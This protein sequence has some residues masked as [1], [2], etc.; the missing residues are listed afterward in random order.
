MSILS[1]FMSLAFILIISN[2]LGKLVLTTLKW[3]LK[4][5]IPIGYF[6]LLSLSQILLIPLLK[7]G[8]SSTT[9][10]FSYLFL[11]LWIMIGMVLYNKK[12]FKL[13]E[14]FQFINKSNRRYSLIVTI[15]VIILT[16][17]IYIFIMSDYRIDRMSDSAFYIP[18][19]QENIM[20]DSIYS[21]NPWSGI[22]E[23]YSP[24]YRY[25]SYELLHAS[26]L[27]LL[28]I[29]PVIYINHFLVLLNI[30]MILLTSFE[31]VIALFK[32]KYLQASTFIIYLSIVFCFV[33]GIEDGFF[34]FFST[35]MIQRLPYSGKVL[36]YLAVIPMFFLINK[37]LFNYP[38][39]KNRLLFG[40]LLI[41]L[42]STALTATSVFVFGIF[43]VV[44]VLIRLYKKD[45]YKLT[46]GYCLTTMPLILHVILIKFHILFIPMIIIYLILFLIYIHGKYIKEL[47]I[48][49]KYVMYIAI[50][51][52][53]ILSI[54][55]NAM[56][57]YDMIE[58]IHILKFIE[59]IGQTLTIR[60]LLVWG[61]FILGIIEVWNNKEIRK[62]EKY[63]FGY[64]PVLI[65]II[66]IN[67]VSSAFISSF[68]T[69]SFVYQ[70]LFYILPLLPLIGYAIQYLFKRFI[71]ENQW[72][73]F[74]M[75]LLGIVLFNCWTPL[76]DCFEVVAYRVKSQDFNYQMMLNTQIVDS[77]LFLK[78][79]DRPIKVAYYFKDNDWG[80][81][82]RY[83]RS[84]AP[85]VILPYNMYTHRHNV[86]NNEFSLEIY[87]QY[88]VQLMLN[89]SLWV[90][91]PY[92]DFDGDITEKKNYEFI[93]DYLKRYKYDF[94][95][96]T[97][98]AE[99]LCKILE[100]FGAS[101]VFENEDEIVFDLAKLGQ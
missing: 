85:N 66:F 27:R 45:D 95:F 17:S 94:V 48:I 90:Y 65:F 68:L 15:T 14:L 78:E 19:I 98:E 6:V 92:V 3:D 44:I 26:I 60:T 28:P 10:Q 82:L 71:I 46:M 64:A 34:F 96:L 62:A 91:D 29:N 53:P 11:V 58:S 40:L 24:L 63:L 88:Q 87:E 83:V 32:R 100:G 75:I 33:T 97:K 86:N 30:I 35:D 69:T 20:T 16:L 49:I 7:V 50:V 2:I 77:T 22:E 9:Y 81:E 73:K 4:F 70:R 8:V 56:D 13:R 47:M 74:A 93:L 43:Y 37:E 1:I 41:N 80:S 101:A 54:L 51:T 57:F 84:I 99:E 21:I 38:M 42:T 61:L 79:I 25:V 72:N 67:P 5:N 89:N 18:M 55:V 59:K 12:N 52:I 31:L 36:T 23:S 76:R 39:K